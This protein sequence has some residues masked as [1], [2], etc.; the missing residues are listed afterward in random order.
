[1][2]IGELPALLL[3]IWDDF[4]NWGVDI[5]VHRN[6]LLVIGRTFSISPIT[7]LNILRTDADTPVGLNLGLFTDF[8]IKN[9]V[10]VYVEPKYIIGNAN[11][12]VISAGVSF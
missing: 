9:N 2:K 6:D 8:P 5:D 1:M 3:F 12:L 11:G 7:G 10:R 4:V